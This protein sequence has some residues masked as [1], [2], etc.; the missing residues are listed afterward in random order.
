MRINPFTGQMEEEDDILPGTSAVQPT[1]AGDPRMSDAAMKATSKALRP[2]EWA[3]GMS[4]GGQPVGPMLTN[5]A[6]AASVMDPSASAAVKAQQDAMAAQA[7]AVAD[8]TKFQMAGGP[9]DAKLTD[10]VKQAKS[11]MI[12]PKAPGEAQPYNGPS[13]QQQLASQA[14]LTIPFSRSSDKQVPD[15]A[16]PRNKV[17][18]DMVQRQNPNAL[19]KFDEERS[20]LAADIAEMAK[21]SKLTT[22]KEWVDQVMASGRI[23]PAYRELAMKLATDMKPDSVRAYESAAMEIDIKLQAGKKIAEAQVESDVSAF[24]RNSAEAKREESNDLLEWASGNKDM[25]PIMSNDQDKEAFRNYFITGDASKLAPG[26]KSLYD[27]RISEYRAQAPTTW[28]ATSKGFGRKDVP[29]DVRQARQA[30]RRLR[31]STGG[32]LNVVRD[33]S[34]ADVINNAK[35]PAVAPV[36]AEVRTRFMDTA[37]MIGVSDANANALLT[38]GNATPQT[39]YELADKA[40]GMSGQ[41]I[42]GKVALSGENLARDV[43]AARKLIDEHVGSGGTINDDSFIQKVAKLTAGGKNPDQDRVR[44]GRALN[45]A[46]MQVKQ[47]ADAEWQ[48][49]RGEAV[50]NARSQAI[51]VALND[52][53]KMLGQSPLERKAALE[54]TLSQFLPKESSALKVD[55]KIESLTDKTQI[56]SSPWVF[57][58]ALMA[59]VEDINKD[60]PAMLPIYKE[61]LQGAASEATYEAWARENPRLDAMLR[62]SAQTYAAGI[63][64]EAE[65][66]A[67]EFVMQNRNLVRQGI[68]EETLKDEIVSGRWDYRLQKNGD[69]KSA[70]MFLSHNPEGE[71]D[72][73]IVAAYDSL[74]GDKR[75]QDAFLSFARKAKDLSVN[76]IPNMYTVGTDNDPDGVRTGIL[77]AEINGS[78]DWQRHYGF[79]SQEQGGLDSLRAI[80]ASISD[81]ISQ[82]AEKTGDT[83]RWKPSTFNPPMSDEKNKAAVSPVLKAMYD[84]GY[85]LYKNGNQQLGLKY[86]KA[87][88]MTA[89]VDE[90]RRLQQSSVEMYDRISRTISGISERLT[91][92]SD[93]KFNG[94]ISRITA[95]LE[96]GSK[97]QYDVSFVDYAV[98]HDDYK[99]MRD[100]VKLQAKST[101]IAQG[102]DAKS[103]LEMRMKILAKVEKILRLMDKSVPDSIRVGEAITENPLL[104]AF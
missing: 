13:S 102:R 78:E 81:Q 50:A 94:D 87:A 89:I 41:P 70:I 72:R 51:S 61:A 9:S 48:Q 77:S 20:E 15:L 53:E 83:P 8:M 37:R 3:A 11:E 34:A 79:I 64:V 74:A 69:P 62:L 30:E 95:A 103:D 52:V 42:T 36:A 59:R 40:M 91:G 35:N 38:L 32:I 10:V 93:G 65:K 99:A 104:G 55:M 24:R 63:K 4:R 45:E 60:N 76:V 86:M 96:S 5:S 80:E 49:K 47:R 2:G 31:E 16:D 101:K 56:A 23:R 29:I 66:V 1:G 92:S 22:E 100:A 17:A 27:E 84:H 98:L 43:D 90:Q 85:D 25:A 19:R 68:T 97:T 26:V 58:Q 39:G 14:Q 88:S 82:Q 12:P 54:Q 57:G 44:W 7:K 67:E 18:R 73:S 21:N 75:E 71:R 6:G 33:G 28:E 46:V